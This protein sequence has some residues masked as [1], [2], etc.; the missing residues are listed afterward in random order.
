MLVSTAAAAPPDV[1]AGLD[2]VTGLAAPAAAP[3]FRAGRLVV[4]SGPA[5]ATRHP[6]PTLLPIDQHSDAD[7]RR[8]LGACRSQLP[9]TQGTPTRRP[10]PP[11]TNYRSY[12]YVI[13]LAGRTQGADSATYGLP[14]TRGRRP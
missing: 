1:G 6:S 7:I 10:H 8:A 13:Q 2:V 12:Y 5:F 14:L 4:V 3:D 9:Y 11:T